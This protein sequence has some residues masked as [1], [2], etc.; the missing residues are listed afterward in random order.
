MNTENDPS[1][2]LNR[3]SV[4]VSIILIALGIS[5]LIPSSLFEITTRVFSLQ[6]SFPVNLYFFSNILITLLTA[7]GMMWFLQSHP[8]LS[9]GTL[10]QHSITPSIT[11]FILSIVLHS[12]KIGPSWWFIFLMGGAVLLLV[13]IAEYVVIEPTDVWFPFSIVGLMS[14]SYLLFLIFLS[15]ISFS[16][17]RLFTVALIVFPISFL[18]TL[19]SIQLRTSKWETGW[20]IGISFVTTQFALVFHYWPITPVQYGVFITGILF[21]L[22]EFSQ[23]ILEKNPLKRAVIEPAVG[24]L[25]FVLIG[26]L[27]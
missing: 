9:R 3:L 17:Q 19:R 26:I 7:T 5:V 2:K 14:L 1:T 12:M 10:I 6:F 8:N 11:S 18:V 24:F 13:I 25:L 23:N 27:L 4:F 15:A 21:S 20:A 16:D 22:V